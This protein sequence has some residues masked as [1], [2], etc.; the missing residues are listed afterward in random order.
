MKPSDH[1]AQATPSESAQRDALA[2]IGMFAA[3]MAHEIRNPLTAIKARLFTL[4]RSLEPGAPAREDAMLI[5]QEITRLERT[6]RDFL[7][8]ARPA[9]PTLAAVQPLELFRSVAALLEPQLCA[10]DIQI[11][12]GAT[13]GKPVAADAHQLRQVLINLVQNAAES[14]GEHG[15]ITLSAKREAA[16]KQDAHMIVLEVADTGKGIPPE[17]RA[18]LFHPFVTDKPSGTGLGLPTAARV[19]QAHGG[20]IDFTTEVDRGTTFRVTL[21]PAEQA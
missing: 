20:T 3:A 2:S 5:G 10:S 16:P 14:I 17:L 9:E 21:P 13:V 7:Q 19:I 1:Q 18:H 6:L 12:I 4:E 8:Y 15:R 11:I